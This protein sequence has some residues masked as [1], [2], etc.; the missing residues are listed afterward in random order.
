ML[1]YYG[2]YVLSLFFTQICLDVNNYIHYCR[3]L[4]VIFGICEFRYPLAVAVMV[5]EVRS[6]SETQVLLFEVSVLSHL[7]KQMEVVGLTTAFSG[8]AVRKKFEDLAIL[9]IKPLEVQFI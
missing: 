3:V 9:N 5:Q 8:K 2:L 4:Q 1:P 6:R 7:K